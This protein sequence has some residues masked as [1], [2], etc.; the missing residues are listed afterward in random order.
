[1]DNGRVEDEKRHLEIPGLNFVPLE[2]GSADV[3]AAHQHVRFGEPAD[4]AAV[5]GGAGNVA[6]G[7]RAQIAR[8]AHFF[9]FFAQIDAHL[10]GADHGAV[11]FRINGYNIHGNQRLHRAAAGDPGHL[12]VVLAGCLGVDVIRRHDVAHRLF[13][14]DGLGL[15]VFR[16]VCHGGSFH[17]ISKKASK[18]VAS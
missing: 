2:N 15:L 5:H 7:V 4:R 12:F 16:V 3:V 14:V 11:V 10:A 9:R 18:R 13:V 8:V 6:A 17:S 1:M